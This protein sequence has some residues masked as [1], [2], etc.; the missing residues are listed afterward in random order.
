M[1][2]SEYG[3][4]SSCTLLSSYKESGQYAT[5]GKEGIELSNK[6]QFLVFILCYINMQCV[7]NL[8]KSVQSLLSCLVAVVCLSEV[9]LFCFDQ[10]VVTPFRRA[11]V[12]HPSPPSNFLLSVFSL[13]LAS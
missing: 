10:S 6:T 11:S 2:T 7:S 9:N 13:Y 1:D 5:F 12:T 4:L 3:D 8:V